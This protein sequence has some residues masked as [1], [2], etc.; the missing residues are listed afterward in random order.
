[1]PMESAMPKVDMFIG[2]IPTFSLH[3]LAPAL[4]GSFLDAC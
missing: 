3:P 4:W 2:T 1:M